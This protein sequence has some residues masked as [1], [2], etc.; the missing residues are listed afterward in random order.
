MY[1]C[2]YTDDLNNANTTFILM[3]VFL[4]VCMFLDFIDSR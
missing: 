1:V 2:M 4:Y 3:Y